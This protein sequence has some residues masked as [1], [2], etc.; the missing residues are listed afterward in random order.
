MKTY[1]VKITVNGKVRI[2]LWSVKSKREIFN[3]LY[4]TCWNQVNKITKIT[5]EKHFT[6]YCG[7]NWINYGL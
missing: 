7:F 5:I 3:D 4:L 6:P 2:Y 1:L